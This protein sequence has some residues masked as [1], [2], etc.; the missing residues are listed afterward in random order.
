MCMNP[1]IANYVPTQLSMRGC[2]GMPTPWL[3]LD[4][5]FSSFNFRVRCTRTEKQRVYTLTYQMW[6]T[7]KKL[8][9]I[10]SRMCEITYSFIILNIQ[11]CSKSGS[12]LYLPLRK[13]CELSLFNKICIVKVRHFITCYRYMHNDYLVS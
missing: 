9:Q 8:N 1:Q 10:I 2:W 12:L 6:R 3:A 4:L 11:L 13:Y 7:E 5:T